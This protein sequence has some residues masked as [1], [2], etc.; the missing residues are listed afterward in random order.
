MLEVGGAVTLYK[1]K[2]STLYV[3]KDNEEKFLFVLAFIVKTF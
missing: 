1:L 2:V 3:A